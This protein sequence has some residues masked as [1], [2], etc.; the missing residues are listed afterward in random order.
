M[1]ESLDGGGQRRRGAGSERGS[2]TMIMACLLLVMGVLAMGSADLA[3]VAAAKGR[4]QTAAD[5]AALAAAQELAVP[6]GEGPAALAEAFA[7]ANGASLVS[8]GCEEG[9]GEARV[10]VTVDTGPLLLLPGGRDIGA[11]ARAAVRIPA[12]SSGISTGSG[13]P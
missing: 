4:A 8:C 6:G 3:R 1:S 7:D 13:A 2:V 10:E 5:L 9:S 11:E 12:L